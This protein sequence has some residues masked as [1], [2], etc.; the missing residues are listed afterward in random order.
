M[1]DTQA[2]ETAAQ[3]QTRN[4]EN[5]NGF[6]LSRLNLATP[7]LEPPAPMINLERAR[8]AIE[9]LLKAV[10]EDPEREGLQKTPERVARAYKELLVGYTLDPEKLINGALFTAQHA[11]LVVVRDIEYHSLCEHHLLPFHGRAT[12]A[13][14]PAEK[15]IGLSKIPRIVDL[16]ARRLQL[17][18]RLTRQVAEFL[19]NVLQP[20]GVAVAFEGSH[21]CAS[22]RGVRKQGTRM[23]TTCLLGAF[24]HDSALRSEFFALAK[25]E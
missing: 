1:S 10:G 25:T 4:D 8:A 6:H 2:K 7:V 17:Q 9:E 13:Y 19:D 12:V 24:E 5:R 15:I 22:M 3:L 11:D 20:A 23:M 21:L 14:L 16:F 18:E